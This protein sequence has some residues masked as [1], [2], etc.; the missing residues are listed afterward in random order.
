MVTK[1]RRH[2][3]FAMLAAILIGGYSVTLIA[4]ERTAFKVCA[5][6]NNLP[7]SNKNGE[8]F[9]NRLA[10]LLAADLGLPVEYTWFPQR[11][12]FV[13]NTLRSQSATG[14]GYK[15]DI[16]MGQPHGYELTITTKPYYRSTYALVYVRGR[17]LDDVQS[18]RDLANLDEARKQKLR[19]G[20]F[21]RSPGIA[22]LNKQN[23]LDQLVPYPAMSG[24]P[25]AYPGQLVDTELVQERIDVAILWG[26]IAGYFA[27]KVQDLE[28]VVIPMLSEEDIRFHFAI[29]AGMRFGEGDWKREVEA[30]L[31][32][33]ADKI[34][35]LLKEY[36]VPLVSEEGSLP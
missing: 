12:G 25:A 2:L 28:L 29:S 23:M 1:T 13:R 5:D 22:W 14:E 18:L 21:E 20:A 3:V 27:D 17:G 6:P 16:V 15:C 19:I 34:Q 33:N 11:L 7:F 9:E 30:L 31:D 10:E 26:P 24:D 36:H 8:G 32:K 35:A 4:A